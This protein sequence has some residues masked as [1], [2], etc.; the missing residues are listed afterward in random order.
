M[1]HKERQNNKYNKITN[2]QIIRNY[3]AEERVNTQ[4]QLVIEYI[5]IN[6]II[7]KLNYVKLVKK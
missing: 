2:N 1:Q 4:I 6:G 7:I 3:M 5:N